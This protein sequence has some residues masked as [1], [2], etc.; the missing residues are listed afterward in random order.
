MTPSEDEKLRKL[1]NDVEEKQKGEGRD[2]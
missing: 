2:R 1:M